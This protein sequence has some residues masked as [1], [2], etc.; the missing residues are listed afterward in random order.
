MHVLAQG[1]GLS[2]KQIA[3]CDSFVYIP[4]YGDG[5]ASLNVTVATSIVLQHFAVWA[6]YQ[7]HQRQGQKFV[8]G[9]K[10]QRMHSRGER[11]DPRTR[12]ALVLAQQGIVGL[13]CI[14]HWQ[15]AVSD[16]CFADISSKRLMSHRQVLW[17][18]PPLK[19]PRSGSGGNSSGNKVAPHLTRATAMDKVSEPWVLDWTGRV[20]K[21]LV[22]FQCLCTSVQVVRAAILQAASG[23]ARATA[24][25]VSWAC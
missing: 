11:M 25:A 19:R 23:T 16:C 13:A 21:Q 7:E 2:E 15:A 4:Q 18:G 14:W 3:L 20:L 24:A 22:R 8:V 6:G 1:Q 10:P 9:D 5:T 12:A 17:R